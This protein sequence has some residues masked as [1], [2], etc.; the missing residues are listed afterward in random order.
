MYKLVDAEGSIIDKK[1]LKNMEFIVDG[2]NYSA[3]SDGVVRINM[4]NDL[5]DVSGSLTIVTYENDFDLKD[6]DYSLVIN[7]YVAHDGRYTDTFAT[8]N[9]SI[10]VVSDYQEILDYDFNVKMDEDS[11]ILVKDSG[12]AVLPFEILSV[13]EFSDPS[14]RVS[15]YK[16]NNLTAYDQIYTLIDL[17]LY[18][19]NELELATDYSYLVS[20]NKLEL[21]LD[22]SNLEKNGYEIRFEL[23]DGDTR[24]DLI[25]KKFIV[26]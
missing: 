15:L 6:G 26:R 16:K 9:I 4:S 21:N 17:D 19:T 12:N 7:P 2:I 22:L 3:D 13:N 14:V 5:T 24:I 11:R 20:G 25:K 23:F 8:T 18:S 1:Y 10:P